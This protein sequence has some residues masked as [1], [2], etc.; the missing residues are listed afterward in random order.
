MCIHNLFNNNNNKCLI[1][2][3][4]ATRYTMT[5]N[6]LLHNDILQLKSVQIHSLV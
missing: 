4:S 5:I 1:N 6:M 3:K 2:V